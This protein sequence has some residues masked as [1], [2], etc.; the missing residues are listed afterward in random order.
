M[1]KIT[2]LSLL[3]LVAFASCKKD[4]KNTTTTPPATTTAPQLRFVFKF[5]STQVRLDG[6]GNPSTLPLNH[7][8]QSPH[9]NGMSAHYIEMTQNN[10]TAIGAGAILYTTPTTTISPAITVW[11]SSHTNSQVYSDAINFDQETVVGDGQQFF[12]KPLSQ[13]T[14]G[15]YPYVRISVAYQNYDIKY[16]I[17]PN[18]PISSTYTTPP[19]STYYSTGTI[20]SFIGYNTLISSYKIKTQTDVVNGAK[21]QGYWTFE[22]APYVIGTSTTTVPYSK[23]QAPQGATTVVSPSAFAT[24]AIPPGSCLVT[25]QFVNASGSAATPLVITGHETNDIVITVSMSTNKSFE[26]KQK[27]GNPNDGYIYPLN[28]DTVVDMGVR[29]MVPKLPQ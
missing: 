9:F 22:S 20:A 28:G 26:W 29:G 16:A 7:G 5:D 11:N 6:F 13:I 1:K 19:G 12:S 15:T 24:T 25:G 8:G 10:M 4:T 23:G 3:V 14:P 27:S 2:I 18:T 17:L 21:Q